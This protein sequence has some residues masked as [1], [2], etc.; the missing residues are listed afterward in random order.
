M[1]IF[2]LVLLQLLLT[3]CNWF[4]RWLKI[5]YQYWWST[6][7]YN[8]TLVPIVYTERNCQ[9]SYDFLVNNLYVNQFTLREKCPYSEFFWSIFSHIRN[10]YGGIPRISPYSV[11]MRENT[12]QKNVENGHFSLSVSLEVYRTMPESLLILSCIMLKNGQ[13]YFKNLTVFRAQDC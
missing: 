13:T 2:R 11:R 1:Y 3:W 8:V 4:F 5:I 12:D 7:V 10:E 6:L 9:V